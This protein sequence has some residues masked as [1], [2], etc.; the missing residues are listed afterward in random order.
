VKQHEVWVKHKN[1]TDHLP[2]LKKKK[3]LRATIFKKKPCLLNTAFTEM[4]GRI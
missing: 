4:D 2:F 3:K 1:K